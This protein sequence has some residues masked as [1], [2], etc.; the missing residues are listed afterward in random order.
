MAVG[1]GGCWRV[2]V[3]AVINTKWVQVAMLRLEPQTQALLVV[4]SCRGCG[5]VG[6]GQVDGSHLA[7]GRS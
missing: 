1:R 3:N 4:Y 5:L 6:A 2:H 7:G